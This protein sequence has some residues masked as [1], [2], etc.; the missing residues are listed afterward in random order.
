MFFANKDPAN[1]RMCVWKS[2]TQ[3]MCSLVGF[4]DLCVCVRD[5]QGHVALSGFQPDI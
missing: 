5:R 3:L 2:E 1:R 4:W